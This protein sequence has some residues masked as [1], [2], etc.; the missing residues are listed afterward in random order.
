MGHRCTAGDGGWATDMGSG[1]GSSLA[2]PGRHRAVSPGSAPPLPSPGRPQERAAPFAQLKPLRGRGQGVPGAPVHGSL[3]EAQPQGAHPLL[4]RHSSKFV[5]SQHPP[6]LR[7][8][9]EEPAPLLRLRPRTG[10]STCGGGFTG[11]RVWLLCL[12]SLGMRD[13]QPSSGGQG[14]SRRQGR[15]AL[16]RARVSTDWQ[17]CPCPE[18]SSTGQ[19]RERLREETPGRPGCTRGTVYA[20]DQGGAAAGR[21]RRRGRGCGRAGL[22]S[23]GPGR[24]SSSRPAAGARSSGRGCRGPGRAVLGTGD[25]GTGFG[26]PGGPGGTGGARGAGGTCCSGPCAPGPP[27]LFSSWR[28]RRRRAGRRRSRAR[29]LRTDGLGQR[30]ALPR[31]P[32]PRAPAGSKR[33][34]PGRGAGRAGRGYLGPCAPG[35]RPPPGGSAAS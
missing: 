14:T 28:S 33:R 20:R 31:R 12:S 22:G 6:A 30:G 13:G 24:A 8:R 34:G 11:L 26:K 35:T 17:L 21:W 25:C 32:P 9:C 10:P 19:G 4:P 1:Q 5:H 2:G 18:K 23:R 7:G 29:P 27:P 3:G 15:S 16:H